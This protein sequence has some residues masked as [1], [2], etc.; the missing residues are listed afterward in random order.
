ME[1]DHKTQ[2]DLDTQQSNTHRPISL[3][4]SQLNAKH[5]QL[6]NQHLPIG[7][8]ETSLESKYID[9]SEEFCRMLGYAKEELL[10][11]SIKDVT[12]EEDYQTDMQLH[13]QL[14]MGEIPYYKIEKRFVRKDGQI[15]WVDLTRS[16]IR[17]DGGNVLYIVGIVLD[18]T[19][20]RLAEEA[21]R[22]SE[23]KF[24]FIYDKLPF[25]ATL[26]KPQDGLILDVND[27]F[28]KVFGYTKQEVIGK[29]LPELGLNPDAE[30]RERILTELLERNSVRGIELTLRTKSHGT[31][32]FLTNMDVV[33]I[34]GES[35]ILQTD[36]DIT[37]R[38]RAL[39]AL[40]ESEERFRAILRQAAAGIVRKDTVGTLLFANDE[41]CKMIGYSSEELISEGKT[42]WDLTHP[43]DLEENQRNFNRMLRDGIPFRMERR[44][45]RKDGSI[46]WCNLSVAPVM[47]AYG[48]PV[49]AVGVEVDITARK[50]M[51][52][53]LLQ[54]NSELENRVEERTAE[55]RSMNQAL[56][57]SRRRLQVLSQRLIQVQEDERRSLA[58]ELHDQVGQSLIALN[59]NLTIIQGELSRGDT[60]VLAT[61]LTDSIELVTEVITLV[62]DVMSNL[63]PT[64]LDDYGLESA[65]Q[66]YVNEFQTRYGIPVQFEKQ[67]PPL[68]RLN[69]NI[70]ITLLRITQEALTNIAR[71][72]QA[73]QA[74]L[75][76]ELDEKQIYLKIEDNGMGIPSQEGAKRPRSHGLK[77]MQE[78]AEALEGIIH[79]RS[80]P[81]QGTKIEVII[82]IAPRE[83]DT[84]SPEPS[85]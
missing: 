36:Q 53:S 1:N 26:T 81:G 22:E 45:I 10:Q 83:P 20:R 57:K 13:D 76:L 75:S 24:S 31:R 19:E 25:A 61:R 7:I 58:R 71:H 63:R 74:V 41:F 32:I 79:I 78:R 42:C 18:V 55:L 40:R 43:D 16:A 17:D 59:L 27:A 50:Q 9:V 47:D 4:G 33:E 52:A 73:S 69:N 49:S 5:Q 39:E 62:R 11:R 15:I 64:N 37:E 38:K 70:E 6:I 82:P 12:K 77:I 67:T 14:V 28:E 48:I 3:S 44:L 80:A 29:T 46:L 30:S 60:E 35:Y 65:L 54:L 68:P 2:E 72:A 8:V 85:I 34:E 51:E 21:L 84:I 56:Q 66:T 23:R